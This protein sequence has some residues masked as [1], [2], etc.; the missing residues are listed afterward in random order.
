M[1]DF[2]KCDA[3]RLLDEG[4]TNLYKKR[5]PTITKKPQQVE[6]VD[7]N[8]EDEE[9]PDFEH[10]MSNLI[11]QQTAA[12]NYSGKAVK[13]DDVPGFHPDMTGSTKQG[14]MISAADATVFHKGKP[15]YQQ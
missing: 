13:E 7:K 5:N 11:M 12:Q 9:E 10:S 3:Q 14:T 6:Y 1:A 4:K 8:A 2:I 15:M